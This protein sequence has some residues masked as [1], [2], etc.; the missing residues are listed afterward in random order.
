MSELT[1]LLLPY[2]D[3]HLD[4]FDPD[5]DEDDA[6]GWR[7]ADVPAGV[8]SQALTLAGDR[9]AR[10]RPNAQP[11]NQWLVGRAAALQGRL[12]GFVSTSPVWLRFDGIQVPREQAPALVEA[13]EADWPAVD[14]WGSALELAL[15]ESWPGWDSAKAQWEGP[16][17]DLLDSLPPGGVIGLWWD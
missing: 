3:L 10:A 11:P 1:A 2:R 8:A 16:G 15:A 5:D 7:F 14:A 17:T 9:V 4:A 6:R 12:V 13:L